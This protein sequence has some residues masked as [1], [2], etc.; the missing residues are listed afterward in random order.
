MKISVPLFLNVSK[1]IK[2]KLAI[3]NLQIQS[4]GLFKNHKVVKISIFKVK[5]S[6]NWVTE[7][8]FIVVPKVVEFMDQNYVKTALFA[9]KILVIRFRFHCSF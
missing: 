9:G 7:L 1:L 6:S 8:Q 5:F 2:I 4:V 3:I